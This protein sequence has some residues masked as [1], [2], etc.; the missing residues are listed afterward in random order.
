MVEYEVHNNETAMQ[1][2]VLLGDKKACLSYR[3]YK[4][5]IA[6]MHTFVPAEFGGKGIAGT[7]AKAAFNYAETHNKQVIVFCPFVASFIQKHT[8]YKAQLDPE[9][10]RAAGHESS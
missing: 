6:F 4:N 10:G 7:L 5:D 3:F 1:F 9:Y 2:E 8:E